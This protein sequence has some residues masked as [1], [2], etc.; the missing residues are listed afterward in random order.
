MDR[1]KEAKVGPTFHLRNV[2]LN[3]SF[4]WFNCTEQ[5]YKRN[6]FGF[7]PSFS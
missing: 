2:V 5:K 6:I 4:C 1:M 7:A 3:K